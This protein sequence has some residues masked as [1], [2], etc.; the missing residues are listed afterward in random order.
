[1]SSWG[2]ETATHG[3]A[4]AGTAS[5]AMLAANPNRKYALITNDGTVAAYIAL[6]TAAAVLNEGIRLAANGGSYEMSR[7]AANVY[8]GAI[9]GIASVNAKV[10]TFEGE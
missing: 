1:M 2:F 9:Q 8:S 6:G 10:L 7:G 3:T 5:S 4:Q